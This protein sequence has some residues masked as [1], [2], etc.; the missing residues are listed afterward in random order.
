[1]RSHQIKYSERCFIQ[2]S[3]FISFSI[4]MIVV[5]VVVVPIF[6][7]INRIVRNSKYAALAQMRDALLKSTVNDASC[8]TKSNQTKP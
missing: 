8:Q 2:I 7:R 5:V 3:T 4:P 1:M 6:R